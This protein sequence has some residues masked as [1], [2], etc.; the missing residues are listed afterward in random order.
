MGTRAQVFAR[1]HLEWTAKPEP[2]RREVWAGRDVGIGVAGP[3]DSSLCELAG[4][5]VRRTVVS[6]ETRQQHKPRPDLV[7][8]MGCNPLSCLDVKLVGHKKCVFVRKIEQMR[9]YQSGLH[10]SQARFE[11]VAACGEP[12][13]S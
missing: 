3:V 5:W 9:K 12:D 6:L 10:R 7:Q 13:V 11:H 4:M 2:G 8:I 1:G